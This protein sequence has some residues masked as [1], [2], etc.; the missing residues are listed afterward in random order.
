MARPLYFQENLARRPF[1][2]ALALTAGGAPVISCKIA[3]FFKQTTK[4]TI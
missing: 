4:K 3:Y 2:I 1:S